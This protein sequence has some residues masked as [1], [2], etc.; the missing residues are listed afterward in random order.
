M[1]SDKE[2]AANIIPEWRAVAAHKNEAGRFGF[3]ELLSRWCFGRR[4]SQ[5]Q[6]APWQRLM[7]TLEGRVGQGWAFHDELMVTRVPKD[8]AAQNTTESHHRR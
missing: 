4:H 3:F 7:L 8:G 6:S 1:K 2:R 5:P